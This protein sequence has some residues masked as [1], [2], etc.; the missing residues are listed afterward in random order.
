MPQTSS[1]VASRASKR[2]CP[3]RDGPPI[4]KASSQGKNREDD[5]AKAAAEKRVSGEGGRGGGAGRDASWAAAAAARPGV[6]LPAMGV[7]ATAAA[8]AGSA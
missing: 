5:A 8:A 7:G 1:R 6:R 3:S 2:G 4:E